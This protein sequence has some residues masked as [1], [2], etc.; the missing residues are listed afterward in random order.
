MRFGRYIAWWIAALLSLA[1]GAQAQVLDSSV[2]PWLTTSDTVNRRLANNQPVEIEVDYPKLMTRQGVPVEYGYGVYYLYVIRATEV[3]VSGA[4]VITNDKPIYLAVWSDLAEITI[5]PLEIRSPALLIKGM[6]DN[7]DSLSKLYAEQADRSWDYTDSLRQ[8]IQKITYRTQRV[9]KQWSAAVTRLNNDLYYRDLYRQFI[10]YRNESMFEDM[11][12]FFVAPYFN[13]RT[14]KQ[15]VVNT[16]WGLPM[17]NFTEEERAAMQD[18]RKG[19]FAFIGRGRRKN[20]ARYDRPTQSSAPPA[21][22]ATPAEEPPVAEPS[23]PEPEVRPVDEEPEEEPNVTPVLPKAGEAAET[24]SGTPEGPSKRPAN[25]AA[26]VSSPS[27]APRR[28]PPPKPAEPPAGEE[29][30]GEERPSSVFDFD[31]YKEPQKKP[32]P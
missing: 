12:L 15:N 23:A 8:V 18:H 29:E 6:I 4:S 26:P 11:G 3:R 24:P 13:D 9:E 22:G 5:E 25:S 21:S 17:L 32:K 1:C 27:P 16:P 7:A 10:T 20:F 2:N 30:G 28:S 19:S 14:L 31:T